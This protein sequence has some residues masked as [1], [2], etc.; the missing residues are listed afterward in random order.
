MKTYHITL[1]SDYGEPFIKTIAAR[2]PD[3]AMKRAEPEK[4][5]HVEICQ[6]V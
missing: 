3:E 5:W 2:S 6:E 4:G 1:R